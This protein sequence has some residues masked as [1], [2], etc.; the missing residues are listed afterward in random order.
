MMLWC[1]GS[2]RLWLMV[3]F[4]GNNFISLPVESMNS[5]C[6][7]IHIRWIQY[8]FI[9]FLHFKYM[10]SYEYVFILCMNSY[11]FCSYHVWIHTFFAV[12]IHMNSILF[13]VIMYEFIFFL[14]CKIKAASACKPRVPAPAWAARA[15][16]ELTSCPDQAAPGCPDR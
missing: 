13:A 1:G 4:H 11:T 12:W 7:W 2:R 15:K 16:P 10:N 3:R 9:Y 6:I 8:E 14:Q 5:Y